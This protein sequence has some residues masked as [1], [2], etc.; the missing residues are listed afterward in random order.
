MLTHLKICNRS[1]K[2]LH[3]HLNANI[4]LI[5]SLILF[6]LLEIIYAP[7]VSVDFIHYSKLYLIIHISL[8]VCSFLAIGAIL[9][10]IDAFY[11]IFC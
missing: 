6:I 9:S 8:L 5:G 7:L 1:E 10:F 11:I 4:L 3:Y 2:T